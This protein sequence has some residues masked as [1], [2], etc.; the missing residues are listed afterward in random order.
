MID[1]RYKPLLVVIFI[2][3]YLLVGGSLCMEYL[4]YKDMPSYLVSPF[5]PEYY[6]EELR[7]IKIRNMRILSAV[8]VGLII[9]NFFLTGKRKEKKQKNSCILDDL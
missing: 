1:P 4:Q 5:I 7:K 3:F 9:L 8:L 6:I 2:I